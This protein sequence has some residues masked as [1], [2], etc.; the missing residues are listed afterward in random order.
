MICRSLR[1]PVMCAFSQ[2]AVGLGATHSSGTNVWTLMS[3]RHRFSPL[4]VEKIQQLVRNLG[5]EPQEWFTDMITHYLS[6]QQC[7][8]IHALLYFERYNTLRT[9]NF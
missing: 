1:V 2:Q 9:F 6:E 7:V 8:G 3:C 5:A 4:S